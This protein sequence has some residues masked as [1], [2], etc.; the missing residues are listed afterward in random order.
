MQ[1]GKGMLSFLIYYLNILFILGKFLWSDGNIYEGDF[2]DGKRT[3]K[4]KVWKKRNSNSNSFLICY[5]NIKYIVGKF[6]Y[7]DGDRYEGDFLD[8]KMTGKGKFLLKNK[9]N[10]LFLIFYLLQ[11]NSSG[12]MAIAIREIG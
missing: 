11:V 8:G 1:T 9:I 4:G 10:F 5:S 3:G 2:L 6:F 12:L 7:V